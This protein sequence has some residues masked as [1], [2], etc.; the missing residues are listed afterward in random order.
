MGLYYIVF[1]SAGIYN[2]GA[3]EYNGDGGWEA[4]RGYG[5][6]YEGGRGGY[7]GGGRVVRGGRGRGRGGYRGRGRGGYGGGD[8]MQQ[9]LGG[10]N[11]YGGA[12][13]MPAQG[14]G[15]SKFFTTYNSSL[16][17]NLCMLPLGP[18]CFGM[19]YYLPR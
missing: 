9:E 10:Y 19:K 3:V 15:K 13:S 12:G 2:N 1:H 7:G 18:V 8:M 4:G 14:R 16:H 11:D 17:L 5:G 6:G